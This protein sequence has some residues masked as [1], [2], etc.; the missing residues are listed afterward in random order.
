MVRGLRHE[1]AAW[2]GRGWLCTA[3]TLLLHGRL[4][5]LCATMERLA[6]RFAAGSVWRRVAAADTGARAVPARRAAS[7]WPR[8]RAWL[9]RLVGW[10]AVGYGTQLPAVL[11][12]P[13]MVALLAACPQAQRALRPLCRML[14]VDT[15]LLRPGSGCGAQMAAGVG[16]EIAVVTQ[17]HPPRERVGFGRI[18]LPRGLL[19]AARRE[20][21]GKLR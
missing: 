11:A 15:G 16:D 2:G 14:A 10:R 13:E 7:V 17:A 18:P 6:A 5:V 9:V 8:R 3:L 19:S 4:G 20:G 21:F 12:Q 1:V